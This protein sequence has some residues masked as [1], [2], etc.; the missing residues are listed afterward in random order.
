MPGG[1]FHENRGSLPTERREVYVSIIL[2]M[3]IHNFL[4][5]TDFKIPNSD[6]D[7]LNSKYCQCFKNN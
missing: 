3:A 4:V 2:K 7:E 1:A 6:L 5:R